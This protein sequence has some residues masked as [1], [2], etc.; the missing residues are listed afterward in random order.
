MYVPFLYVND[1]VCDY[2]LCCD[3]SEEFQGVG[4][5]KCENRCKEIGKEHRRLEEE[6][7]RN[8]ERAGN[9]RKAM[10][11]EAQNLRRQV[12]DKLNGLR[13]EIKALEVKKEELQKKHREVEQQENFKV[14]K[15]EGSGGKIGVL[16][17]LAKTR[18]TELRG[19]LQDV[20]NQRDTLRDRVD[21]LEAI[22]KRFQKEY[23]PNFNDE[24]VKSAVKSFQDYSARRE[25]EAREEIEDLPEDDILNVLTEDNEESGINWKEFEDEEAQDTDIRKSA[26]PITNRQTLTP[27][28]YNF[29]AYL[30]PFLRTIIHTQ[31]SSL[32][33]WLIENGMLADSASTT[34]ESH[35]LKAAREAV[36]AT[37]RDLKS[38]HRSLDATQLDLDTDHGPSDIFR[39]VKDKCVSM[40]AGEYTY[41]L[42]WLDKT[43]QKSKKGHG[44]SM[45][46]VFRRVDYLMA[47]EEERLDG[48]SLG[49]GERMVLRYE[50]GQQCWNGPKRRTDVWLACAETEEIWRV[51]EMEKCVYKME[52]GTPAACE[53]EEAI[54]EP[55]SK[56]E[57]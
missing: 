3:G 38:K 5:V 2:D 8:L 12:E 27:P 48:K 39:A 47:D 11:Q 4:G 13:E 43:M 17:G 20:V 21:E 15:S 23:N 31:L 19:T 30:P 42:C 56:D 46:G 16:L 26:S 32:R 41:E 28:V 50:D 51:S 10:I 49:T 40:D 45:M 18:V 53:V 57:L 52:V 14:V 55:R 25:I 1:G 6:K 22:L 24:G 7:R 35:L 44:S 37:D 34:S 9:K 36:E 54:Q 33:I 29:E